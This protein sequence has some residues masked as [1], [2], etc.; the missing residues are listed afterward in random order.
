MKHL[1]RLTTILALLVAVGLLLAACGGGETPVAATEAPPVVAPTTAATNTAPPTNTAVPTDTP[2]PTNTPEPTAT[3]E[4][5]VSFTEASDEAL[6][7]TI[8]HP[9]GWV[10][11][12]ADDGSL[13]LASEQ[14]LL[15][16]PDDIKEG[17]MVQA[18]N[19]PA[20]ALAFVV[21][22]G[23]PNDPVAVLNAFASLFAEFSGEDDTTLTVREEAA[24]T[25]IAGFDAATAVYD[26]ISPDLEGVV[27]LVAISDPDNAR[28][29]FIFGATPSASQEQYLPIFDEMLNSVA[30]TAPTA[31]EG[32]ETTTPTG[33]T[34]GF[35]LPGDV[36]ENSVDDADGDAWSYIGLEGE[37]VDITVEPA[38]GFDLEVDVLDADGNSVIGGKLDAVFDTEVIEGLAFPAA[39]DYLIVVTGFA[40]ATGDY[41]LT[42]AE[43]GTGGGT[44]D[45]GGVAPAGDLTIDES[46]SGSITDAEPS[47][48][49][50]GAL[51]N[52]FVDVIVTPEDGFDVVV[53]VLDADGNSLLDS[54][55]D[56][57]F[58]TEIVPV[59]TIPADGL[60]TV[61]VS[62]FEGA[63]GDYDVLVRYSNNNQTNTIFFATDSITEA[64]EEHNFPF[65]AL[66]GD[67]VTA[68][69]EP[70]DT[71]F[72][73]VLSMFN[74]DTDELVE[75]VDASFGIETMTFEVPDS[76]NY[77]F[78]ITGL[79]GSVGEYDVVLIGSETVIYELAIGDEVFS[80]FGE[81]A[82]L[83][84]YLGGEAG[85]T[86]FILVE[87]DEETD[88][89]L[90]V[91]D[92]D[93]NV[94]IEDIDV[95]L[96]GESEEVE[97]TFGDEGLVI[98]EVV[99][100]W[101]LLGTFSM[102]IE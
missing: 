32:T 52:D 86:A 92:T 87:P 37:V 36:V 82:L 48:W 18:M 59:V 9:E 99:D 61:Q 85:D 47:N 70:L 102:T 68:I 15:D 66:E 17:M 25:E 16:N 93:G 96:S 63:T 3:S 83:Q 21:T 77:Y 11:D 19:L 73:A 64:E 75:E 90:R 44:S 40:G 34:E 22:D 58:G 43:A 65:N 76:G 74:D 14:A 97:Y 91:T 30:L 88:V 71:E 50:F 54:P 26:A 95:G 79:D 29:V 98:I 10:T 8:S 20:E 41:T 78:S 81:A 6:G 4:P 31:T 51:E 27:K 42:V 2:A 45:N 38:E 72:D 100:F 69:V 57:S 49:T 33:E 67:F 60:Y 12:V 55:T 5:E 62:G 53:D 84:Y 24:A 35:L 101:E 7:I 28:V 89:V 39:G 80:K 94:L 13:Q 46:A 1:Q 23:D 56:A